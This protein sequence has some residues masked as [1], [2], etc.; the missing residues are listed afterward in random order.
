MVELLIA[1][2]TLGTFS[3]RKKLKHHLKRTADADVAFCSA[4]VVKLKIFCH[5]CLQ[6]SA[7]DLGITRVVVVVLVVVLFHVSHFLFKRN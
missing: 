5:Y 7:Q 1:E 4:L 3:G 6:P 2:A